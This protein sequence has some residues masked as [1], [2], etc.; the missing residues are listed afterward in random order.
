MWKLITAAIEAGYIEYFGLKGTEAKA[1]IGRQ[2]PR[3]IDVV[4]D[5][6]AD[7]DRIEKEAP[8]R[9]VAMHTHLLLL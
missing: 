4:Q 1:M 6:K 5:P 3:I 8:H 9:A 2:A 7:V